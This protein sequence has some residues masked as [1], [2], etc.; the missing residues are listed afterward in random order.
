MGT[1]VI[2]QLIDALVSGLTTS[3]AALPVLVIDGYGTDDDPSDFLM[4]GIDDPLASG[5]AGA[6]TAGQTPGPM[7]T[8][9]PR[10]QEGVVW[11]AAYSSN[12]D[13]NQ[14]T[15]RDAAYSYMAAVEAL[16]RSN[17]NLGIAAGGYFVAQMGDDERLM[18]NQ[19]QNGAEAGLIFNV[20]FTARI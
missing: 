2:P 11:C 4:I 20:K 9:R 7:A 1:S 8:T 18:Q 6:A 15:A 5:P 16:L 14:K 17:P 3:L 10:D 13:A 19:D 12:G